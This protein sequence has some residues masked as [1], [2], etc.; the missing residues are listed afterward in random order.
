VLVK[1]NFEFQILKVYIMPKKVTYSNGKTPN[2]CIIGAGFSGLCAA[3]KLKEELGLKTF[4]L[5]ESLK[6]V[7]GTWFSNTYP[8]CA[9]DIPSH[10]YS[11]SFEPNAEWTKNYSP[12]PE[13]WKYLERVTKKYGIYQH[14]RFETPV[15]SSTWDESTKKWKVVVFDKNSNQEEEQIFDIVINATGGLRVPNVPSQF[16]AFKGP[17]THSAEWDHS[18]KLDNKI[19]GIVG[20]GASAIQIIPN[21]A[22]RVKE[23]HVFQRKPAWVVYRQQWQF[24]EFLKTLFVYLPFLM[25]IY[26]AYLYLMNEI[27]HFTFKANS[28]LNGLAK[29]GSLKYLKEQIP[30]NDKLRNDLTPGY[31]FGCKRLL[32]TNDYYP[33]LNLSHVSVHAGKIAK[34]QDQTIVMENGT[35]KKLD[36]LIL[37]TGFRVHDYFG[38][39]EIFGKNKENI[40]AKWKS[41]VPRAYY[42]IVCSSTP[43]LFYLLG[44]NTAL[45]HNSVVFMIECQV[46]FAIAVIK[47]MIEKD[48]KRFAVKDSVEDEY[49]KE[50]ES[51]MAKTVWGT[52]DCGSWY[53]NAAGV[54]TTL[55]PKNCTSYWNE[56]RKPDLAK[57]D[58]K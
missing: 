48:A 30:E 29:K 47:E 39:H 52:Q 37:A 6:D 40:L 28:F 8:G 13:I 55:W 35:S 42:G 17:M 53:V 18:I 32:P 12:Q 58:F 44:P 56:T 9:C 33:A 36:V 14:V 11:F 45:G 38:P 34:V 24:P 54:N 49:M 51:N 23:L 4:T 1:F 22:S 3:I 7:G 20:S 25:L 15:K 19:V 16:E 27:K 57:F 5:F 50:M 10:L 31:A 43:N 21:I 2:V 46:T 26:R 41:T